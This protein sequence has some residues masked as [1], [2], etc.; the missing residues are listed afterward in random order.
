MAT[1]GGK[2]RQAGTGRLVSYWATYGPVDNDRHLFYAASFTEDVYTHLGCHEASLPFDP[3]GIPSE[4][5]V[6]HHLCRHID[7]TEF[8]EGKRPPPEVIW[9]LIRLG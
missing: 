7:G 1:V 4:A 8:G 5:L 9:R 2:H 3:N 6:R